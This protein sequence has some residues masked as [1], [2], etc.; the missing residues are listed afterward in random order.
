MKI[1]LVH[2]A[3]QQYGGED[4]VFAEE[5]LLLEKMGYSVTRYH[6]SNNTIKNLTSL[7]LAACAPG[8][9][10]NHT[11][12]QNTRCLFREMKSDLVHFHNIFP[13]LSPAVYYAARAER[14]PVVQTLHNYRLLC[15]N[16]F[17]FRRGQVCRECLH[18]FFLLPALI[19][20]CYRNNRAATTVLALMLMVHRMLNTWERMVDFFI[21]PSSF[22]REQFVN[23]GLPGERMVVKPHFVYPD[24]GAGE[25]KGRFAVFI[26]RLSEEK[27]IHTLLSAW[28][29]INGRI[30][31]KII[32]SGPL[33][34]DVV[35]MAHAVPN[36]QY[37]GFK[38]QKEIYDIVG[39]ASVLVFPSEW[40]E[41]FGLVSVEAFAKGTPVIASRI[42]SL[43][44]IVEHGRTGLLFQPGD[45]EDLAAKVEWIFSYPRQLAKMRQ[46]T[47]AEYLSRYTAEKNG[48]MLIAIYEKAYEHAQGRFL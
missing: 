28:K 17:L 15:P 22:S 41:T 33:V 8:V 37:L 11:A 36:L 44:E 9:I 1:S 48:K 12:Y 39:N 24:P 25:G 46:E 30:P 45:E 29:R 4:R 27:G 35:K 5:A 31:L 34:A 42:G 14:V 40:N 18:N 21:V 7:Q 43:A 20:R 32:G 47:R 26:G 2:N 10:W 19:Y 23:A 6:V 38:S 13:L 3:Y 16:A